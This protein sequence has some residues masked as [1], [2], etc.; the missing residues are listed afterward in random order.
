[1]HST[2]H[3]CTRFLTAA[4]Q[5]C[6]LLVLSAQPALAQQGP[7]VTDQEIR[8]GTWLP[9]T[10]P[11]APYGLQGL[12]GIQSYLK[13][14]NDAGGIKGRKF[15]LIAEDNNFNPQR[16]VAA[17]RKLISRDEVL[18]IIAPNG[19][20]QTAAA[21]EYVLGEAKVPLINPYAGAKDWYAPVRENLYG[22]QVPLED[23]AKIV[24]RWAAKDGH[25]KIVI[26]H[27]SIAVT[28]R[29]AKEATEAIKKV[30]PDADIESYP[31]KIG[32]SDF[33]PIALDISR[34]APDALLMFLTQSE[35]V[36]VLKEVRQQQVRAPV[37]S[38][39][40]VVLNELLDLTG[41]ASEGMKAVSYTY[42]P[43]TD[44]RAIREYRDAL[45]KYFPS[46]KPDYVS[47]SVFGM[48]KIFVEAVRRIDGPINRQT[49]VKSLDAMR[50]YDTGILPPASYAA[51][52]HLAMTSL[53]RVQVS[54]GKWTT[55]GV[56]VDSEKDW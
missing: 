36:G 15:N 18:A 20:G 30:R 17:A 42:P 38:Y 29:L 9:L 2:V 50:N 25:K 12:A 24:G 11:V 45:A 33:G 21:L 10:G 39:A 54:G 47:L 49:L 34:K 26:A 28:E 43:T 27:L 55:V 3:G 44:T 48:T 52:R 46:E 19:T 41:T 7:G 22:A 35:S 4:L 56:P 14:V 53:Q 1:M 6:L 31:I 8:L 40:G 23:Q 5:A 37:Y 13:M 32:T 16:T 51:D